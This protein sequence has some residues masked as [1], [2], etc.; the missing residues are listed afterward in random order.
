[1]PTI[2]VW[3]KSI[4][5]LV[6]ATSL[7]GVGGVITVTSAA[8]ATSMVAVSAVNLRSGPGTSYAVVTVVPGGATVSAT[9]SS[10]GGWVPVSYAGR[11]GYIAGN[12]L[13]AAPSGSA[14]APAATGSATATGYVN[15]RT[16]PSTSYA[17]I[18]VAAPGQS[19][20][21]TGTTSGNWTQVVWSGRTAWISSS[22]LSMTGGAV[23]TAE[24]LASTLPAVTGQLRTTAAVNLRTDGNSA[25]PIYGTVPASTV[26]DVTGNTTASYTQVVFAGRAL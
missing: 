8:A 20:S 7:A 22:Y 4:A 17:V 1:M 13:Q 24:P 14:E 6:A 23:N 11:R 3:K 15:V 21:T 9:G 18:A 5:A 19:V 2:P 12:Y 16:G 25:A 10:T 26:V